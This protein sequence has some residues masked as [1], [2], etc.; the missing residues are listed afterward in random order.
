MVPIDYRNKYHKLVT[1]NVP[2]TFAINIKSWRYSYTHQ[3]I[4]KENNKFT[5]SICRPTWR[6]LLAKGKFLPARRWHVSGCWYCLSSHLVG[7]HRD[8]HLPIISIQ[9]TYVVWIS[10]ACMNAEDMAVQGKCE[11]QYSQTWTDAKSCVNY[12]SIK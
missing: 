10:C 1:H 4:C 8:T 5:S 3:F 11:C 12:C 2:V 9:V 7:N 6:A